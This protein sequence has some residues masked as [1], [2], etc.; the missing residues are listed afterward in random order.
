M[1]RTQLGETGQARSFYDQ[2][3]KEMEEHA[4]GYPVDDLR[5][6]ADRLLGIAARCDSD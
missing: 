6:E 4:P 1:A 5:D 2:L 3:V